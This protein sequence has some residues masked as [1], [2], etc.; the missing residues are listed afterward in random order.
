MPKAEKTVTRSFRISDRALGSIEEESKRQ[1][2]SVSTIINQQLLA[3]SEF[4]RFFRRLGLIKI[5]SATF[6]RLL[7][8]GSDEFVAK[9][10]IEAGKDTPSSIILA[11]HGVQN[12][13]TI[14]DY[15]EMLSEFANQF[16][17]G[18]IDQG[19]KMV[20]TLL[21]RLGPKGSIFFENYVKSLFG[22]TNYSPNIT[23]TEHSVVVEI[24]PRREDNSK[25]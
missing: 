2:V 18:R 22:Q 4:E 14:F 9:A 7:E 17:L 11:K 6:Q 20:I 5:S 25:F 3:Y 13:D 8:A 15:L 19:G 24:V 10:G 16:E 21:H 23:S 1:N 12:L